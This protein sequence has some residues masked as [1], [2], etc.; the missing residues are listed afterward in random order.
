VI[1]QAITNFAA[2]TPNTQIRVQKDGYYVL[3]A[4]KRDGVNYNIYTN[5]P[6]GIYSI[7]S[8]SGGVGYLKPLYSKGTIV[9]FR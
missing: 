9:S 2:G 5:A 3:Y 8:E 4:Y 1:Y 7:K 6:G